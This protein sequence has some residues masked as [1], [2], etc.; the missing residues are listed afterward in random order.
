MAKFNKYL[1]WSLLTFTVLT[2]AGFIVF[3]NYIGAWKYEV[4][5]LFFLILCP[6]AVSAFLGIRDAIVY[7]KSRNMAVNIGRFYLL[8]AAVI[9]P[10]V[11]DWDFLYVSVIGSL[12]LVASYYFK[13]QKELQLLIINCLGILIVGLFAVAGISGLI[14]SF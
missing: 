5:L 2:Y 1:G 13:S 4:L 6:F 9:I 3:S 12:V 10:A 11:A 14:E 7:P 8:V